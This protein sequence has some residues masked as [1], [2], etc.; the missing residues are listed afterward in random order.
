MAKMNEPSAALPLDN[1]DAVTRLIGDLLRI[2]C[3]IRI[4]VTTHNRTLEITPSEHV[5]LDQFLKRVRS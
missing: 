2:G 4:V 3:P 5:P 1:E